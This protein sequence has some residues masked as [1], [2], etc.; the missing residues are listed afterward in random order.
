MAEQ[1]KGRD[2]SVS[3]TP[4]IPSTV[5]PRE[6]QQWVSISEGSARGFSGHPEIG[7]AISSVETWSGILPLG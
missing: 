1:A 3:I 4:E 5:F 7:T 2:P 6:H